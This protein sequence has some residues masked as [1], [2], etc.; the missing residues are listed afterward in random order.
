MNRLLRLPYKMKT[1]RAILIDWDDTLGDWTNAAYMSQQELYE[2]HHLDEW[3]PSFEAWFA[4]YHAHNNELWERYGRGEITKAFLKR[5]RFLYPMLHQLG[6]SVAP[7][8]LCRLADTMTEEF[9]TKTNSHFRLLPDAAEVVKTLAQHYPLTIVSNGFHEVQY[10]KL[11]HSG[12]QSCFQHVL[13]SDEVGI[14]KPQAGIFLEALKR[15]GVNADEAVMIGDSY[16][17]D[18]Q[19]AR[20]VGIDQIWVRAK[21]IESDADERATYEVEHLRDVLKLLVDPT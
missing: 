19:G 4:P 1:Y 10:Y 5:D 6:L 7:E 21:G 17:S 2:E 11:E 14:N 18:I 15:N 3:F 12:L 8:P 9:L 20:A 16:N 13:I